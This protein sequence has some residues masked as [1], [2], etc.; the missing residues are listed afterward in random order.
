MRIKR[1]RRKCDSG[2]EEQDD[3][4][5]GSGQRRRRESKAAGAITGQRQQISTVDGEGGNSGAG[6]LSDIFFH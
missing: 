5:G 2:T 4:D 6:V 1:W 3:G